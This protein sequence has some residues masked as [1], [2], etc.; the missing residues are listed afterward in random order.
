M[1]RNIFADEADREYS[2]VALRVLN[3][4][5]LRMPV[6]KAMANIFQDRG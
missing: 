3:L 1:I 4:A 2:E 5:Q 6:R